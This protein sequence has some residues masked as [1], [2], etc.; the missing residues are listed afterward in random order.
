MK[1]STAIKKLSMAA[2]G[3]ALFAVGT[4][5]MG[6]AEQAQAVTLAPNGQWEFGVIDSDPANNNPASWDFT[7]APGFKGAFDVVDVFATG[8]VYDIFNGATLL[9]STDFNPK[10]PA[11]PYLPSGDA[12][13]D[14]YW[15]DANPYSSASFILG[16]GTYSI[17]LDDGTPFPGGLPAGYNV[18]L[19]QMEMPATT[20]EPASVLGLLALGALGVGSKLKR[21][22][23]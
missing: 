8:D 6:I 19:N 1:T 11:F 23:K 13:L 14:A 18:R 4:F 3:A 12:N 20:P 16:P 17:S 9:G 21:K 22:L 15:A 7:I 10:T 2:T 5:G